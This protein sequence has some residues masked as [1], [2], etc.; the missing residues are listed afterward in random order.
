MFKTV[1]YAKNIGAVSANN[2]YTATLNI[3]QEGYVPI[4]AM[5]IQNNH[6]TL[7]DIRA[8]NF[9]GNYLEIFN[10]ATASYNEVVVHAT[11]VYVKASFMA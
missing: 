4:G 9:T 10:W 5:R 8:F 11:V 3:A 2:M 6:G 7:V 1:E